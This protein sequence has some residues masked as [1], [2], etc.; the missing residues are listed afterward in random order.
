MGGRKELK[1]PKCESLESQVFDSRAPLSHRG[2]KIG[3]PVPTYKEQREDFI[4]YIWRRRKC[5]ACG[6]RFSTREYTIKNL[7]DFNKQSYL[8]MIDELM[9]D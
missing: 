3:K 6:H 4:P 9:P 1:C 7:V 2:H 5:L 8:K